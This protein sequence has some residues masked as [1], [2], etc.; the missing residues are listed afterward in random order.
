MAG[1]ARA[2][3]GFTFVELMVAL[4]VLGAS[5]TVLLSAHTSAT[6]LSAHARRLF[7]ATTLAREILTKTEVEGLPVF[8]K[9]AGDFGPD[10]PAYR[11]EREVGPVGT[12]PFI[13]LK[14]VTVRVLWLEGRQTRSTQFV[15]YHLKK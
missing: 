11:W 6:R 12:L 2:A 1:T 15:F 13:D 10:Y 4:A 3:R 14:E 7:E 5:F 8:E 9:D